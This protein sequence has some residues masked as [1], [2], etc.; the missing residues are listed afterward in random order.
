MNEKKNVRFQKL[1]RDAAAQIVDIHRN[2]FDSE[3]IALSIFVSSKITAFISSLFGDSS[4]DFTGA[5]VDDEL[6]G[7]AHV[8]IVDGQPHLNYIAMKEDHQ[9]TGVGSDLLKYL[10]KQA[11]QSG[12]SQ[13][14]LDVPGSNESVREWYSRSGFHE[15]SCDNIFVAEDH[16]VKPA[17]AAQV[18]ISYTDSQQER[19]QEF[20]IAEC[21]VTVGQTDYDVG[22]IGDVLFRVG[23]DHGEDLLTALHLLDPNRTIVITLPSDVALDC[24]ARLMETSI[25][26][27]QS[28]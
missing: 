23:Q 16:G 9:S 10:L 1:E 6:V 11:R 5:F 25:R 28:L 24:N 21:R 20:E 12:Y 8:R 26:M 18:S 4:H 13:F 27:I 14:T 19:L 2:A 22:V 7:Y 17:D 15:V 3:A